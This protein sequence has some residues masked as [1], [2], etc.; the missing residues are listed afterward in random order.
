M[1]DFYRNV[2]CLMGLPIDAIS[3][4]EAAEVLDQSRLSR[5]RCFFSTPN[6]NFVIASQHNAKF[7]SSVSLS[8]LSLADGM[9]LVWVAKLLA[10][11]L[12]GRVSGS[13]LFEFLRYE[14]A[15]VWN[16]FFFGGAKGIGQKACSAI[17]E[18]GAGMQAS[19]SIYPGFVDVAAMSRPDMI[20]R[21]NASQA[22]FLVV[23]LGAAKGQEWICRNLD[24][25]QVPVVAHLGAVINFVAGTVKRA[26]A[27]MQQSG[28]EWV[29]RIM[30]ERTLLRR[31]VQ[32]GMAFLTLLATQAIPLA[33]W[34]RWT[35]PAAAEFA[36]ARVGQPSPSHGVPITLAG[37][38]RLDNLGPI[39]RLFTQLLK[40]AQ[41]VTLDISDVTG[42]D[43]AFIGLLLLLDQ[44]LTSCEKTLKLAYVSPSQKRLLRLSGVHHL[45]LT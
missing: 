29:W 5:Q 21:I 39:R 12:K 8:D 26:P 31:Y 19:G 25:L 40:Q 24:R 32:D 2:H 33:L 28:L 20:D 23:S 18:H 6:L 35:A 14:S 34:Q 15:S 16:V 3:L 41:D 43:S 37:A 11:P 9:P 10:V 4:P 17:G 27:W 38:W 36:R 44:A 45:V 13:S 1:V 22:D 42:M 7:R 30:E